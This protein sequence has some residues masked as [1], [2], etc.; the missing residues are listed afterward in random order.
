MPARPIVQIHLRQCCICSS[1]I[2]RCIFVLAN[3]ANASNVYCC[4]LGLIISISSLLS[5]ISV[6]CP[7]RS[8]TRRGNPLLVRNLLFVLS[9]CSSAT[10]IRAFKTAPR[11]VTFPTQWT[12]PLLA[13]VALSDCTHAPPY[14]CLV[15]VCSL[16]EKVI[17]F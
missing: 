14:G 6:K 2:T 10:A 11:V 7:L 9:G 16:R 1:A 4:I 17:T 15:V 5:D 12:S 3:V 13:I 8:P